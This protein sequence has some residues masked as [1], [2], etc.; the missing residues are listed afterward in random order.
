MV[1]SNRVGTRA[2]LLLAAATLGAGLMAGPWGAPVRA[3]VR[4]LT[5]TG[6]VAPRPPGVTPVPGV[7]PAHS[8]PNAAPSGPD[9]E[10]AVSAALARLAAGRTADSVSVAALDATTGTRVA[11]GAASGMTTASVFKLSLLES[12][13]LQNQDRGQEPGEGQDAALVAM[14]ENSDNDSADAVYEALGGAVGVNAALHRLGLT[15]TVLGADDH[16]GLSTTSAGDQLILLG[17]LAST[18]SPLSAASRAYALRLTSNVEADQ[19]WGVGAAA[20]P[21]TD[22][23]NK[24]GWLNVDDDGGRWVVGSVGVIQAHG[25]EILLAVLT[26]HDTDLDSGIAF[27]ESVARTVTTTLT[28]PGQSAGTG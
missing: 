24:N 9:A 6:A 17:D 14:V 16:W 11:W 23:A 19:R 12:Y 13:L 20:D 4:S 26:Q 28:L 8:V 2:A 25:H 7:T 22:F 1:N 10:S 5:E 18:T 3:E 15:S 21:G 27:V